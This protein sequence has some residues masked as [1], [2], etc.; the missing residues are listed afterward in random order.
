MFFKRKQR[1][2]KCAIRIDKTY[3]G[4]RRAPDFL[5]GTKSKIL[6]TLVDTKKSPSEFAEMMAHE[7]TLP[8]APEIRIEEGRLGYADEDMKILVI[9]RIIYTFNTSNKIVG[10][11]KFPIR[12]LLIFL[13]ASFTIGS[14]FIFE[15]FSDNANLMA[16]LATDCTVFTEEGKPKYVTVFGERFYY[17]KDGSPLVVER[18]VTPFEKD[19]IDRPLVHCNWRSSDNIVPPQIKW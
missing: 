4:V 11:R 10:T 18:E 9:A 8:E 12:W 2:E 17:H 16:E 5:V 19:R 1:E 15:G 14:A 6:N 3:D 13:I 7:D